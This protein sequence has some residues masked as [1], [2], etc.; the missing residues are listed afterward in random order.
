[1]KLKFPLEL[2]FGADVK[3]SIDSGFVEYVGSINRGDVLEA[4]V[5]DISDCIEDVIGKPVEF[6]TKSELADRLNIV[7]DNW[8]WWNWEFHDLVNS[9]HREKNFLEFSEKFRK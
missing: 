7:T 6:C 1:M 2:Y 5:L 9:Y 8:T 4:Y 3:I